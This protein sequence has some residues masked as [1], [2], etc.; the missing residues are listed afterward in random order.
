MEGLWVLVHVLDCV[1]KPFL[2]DA[3]IL[4]E[5]STCSEKKSVFNHGNQ[6]KYETGLCT[7]CCSGM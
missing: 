7:R 4:G 5:P 2:M 1:L 3:M 6:T